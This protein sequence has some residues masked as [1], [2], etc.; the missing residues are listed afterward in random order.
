MTLKDPFWVRRCL[1]AT[2][3]LSQPRRSLPT[4]KCGHTWPVCVGPV[5]FLTTSVSSTDLPNARHV[6]ISYSTF[7]EDCTVTPVQQMCQPCNGVAPSK[8]LVEIRSR[9]R[10]AR[11]ST[12]T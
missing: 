12:P 11:M 1:R 5:L 4:T 9:D 10:F 2:V 3:L 6:R 7:W 8:A